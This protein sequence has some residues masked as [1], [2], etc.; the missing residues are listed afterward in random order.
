MSLSKKWHLGTKL[1]I[2]GK[3]HVTGKPRTQNKLGMEPP[4]PSTGEDS[5][6][7]V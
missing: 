5:R 1:D 6:H 7:A 4:V 3:A 2:L